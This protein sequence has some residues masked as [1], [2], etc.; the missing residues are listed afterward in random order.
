MIARKVTLSYTK[1]YR[2]I[3]TAESV[4]STKMMGRRDIMIYKGRKWEDGSLVMIFAQLGLRHGA[5]APSGL[6]RT[7]MSGTDT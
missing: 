3:C 5:M 6:Q 4:E 2:C 7:T 1:G